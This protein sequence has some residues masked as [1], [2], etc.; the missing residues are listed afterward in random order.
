MLVSV[1]CPLSELCLFVCLC[2]LWVCMYMCMYQYQSTSKK[3]NVSGLSTWRLNAWNTRQGPS[4]NKVQKC[5]SI[6]SISKITHQMWRDHPFSQRH[7]TTEWAIG[8]GVGGDR[9]VGGGGGLEKKNEK[10][11]VG[12]I[13]WVFIK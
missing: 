8:M 9:G 4:G 7:R 10:E 3:R 11:G 12:N 6:L 1:Y 5:R 13:G 2:V